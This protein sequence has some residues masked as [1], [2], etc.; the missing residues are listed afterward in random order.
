MIKLVVI[1]ILSY[2]LFF[3]VSLSRGHVKI[4][5]SLI[6]AEKSIFFPLNHAVR[7]YFFFDSFIESLPL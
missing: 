6:H 3:Q 1:I 4:L 2:L 5:Y 7:L